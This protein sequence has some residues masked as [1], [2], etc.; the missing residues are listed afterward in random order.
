M[1]DDRHISTI[2]SVM[3]MILLVLLYC[4][5]TWQG[6]EVKGHY[7]DNSNHEHLEVF[8]DHEHYPDG[9]DFPDGCGS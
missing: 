1:N 9:Y 2:M 5:L 6:V 3:W 8:P 4:V 7:F